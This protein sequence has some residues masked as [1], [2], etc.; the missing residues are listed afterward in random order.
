MHGSTSETCSVPINGAHSARIE[1]S[2]QTVKFCVHLLVT[3]KA[4]ITS[5]ESC[6]VA[7]RVYGSTASA[8][9]TLLAPNHCDGPRLPTATM[10]LC[11]IVAA[12]RGKAQHGIEGDIDQSGAGLTQSSACALVDEGQERC[13]APL[14]EHSLARYHLEPSELGAKPA[15]LIN[16]GQSARSVTHPCK[17]RLGHD[18]TLSTAPI[19]RVFSKKSSSL[20]SWACEG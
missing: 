10:A 5:S 12:W 18:A 6:V 4:S 15:M 1:Q 2:S 20:A 16:D 14:R 19:T 13:L 3:L 7:R 8:L 9:S 17:E 11:F